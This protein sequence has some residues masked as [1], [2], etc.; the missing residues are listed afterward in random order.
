MRGRLAAK[1]S[2]ERAAIAKAADVTRIMLQL[3]TATTPQ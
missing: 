3:H 2:G 1:A